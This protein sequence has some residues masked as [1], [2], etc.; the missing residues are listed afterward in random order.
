MT[1]QE[2][3]AALDILA[4]EAA[5]E[6]CEELRVLLEKENVVEE[7]GDYFIVEWARAADGHRTCL[8]G[9]VMHYRDVVAWL[10]FHKALFV[11]PI[12]GVNKTDVGNARR[13]LVK[14]IVKDYIKEKKVYSDEYLTKVLADPSI[15]ELPTPDQIKA[16]LG[17]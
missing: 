13:R 11:Y 3:D 8:L 6:W 9:Q 14:H 4:D 1:D 17:R 12:A 2:R 10:K 7:K 5:K 16:S 15:V